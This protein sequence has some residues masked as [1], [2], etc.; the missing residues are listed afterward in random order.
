[1][2]TYIHTYTHTRPVAARAGR[3]SAPWP[4]NLPTFSIYLIYYLYIT[5]V[6]VLICIY[7]R[8]GTSYIMYIYIYIYI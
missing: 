6:I 8:D 5:Y 1:M 4:A 7:M 2:H 3:L